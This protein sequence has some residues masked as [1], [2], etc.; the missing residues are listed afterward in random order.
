M[1]PDLCYIVKGWVHER[2]SILFGLYFKSFYAACYNNFLG[3]IFFL[4]MWFNLVIIWS[5][6]PAIRTGQVHMLFERCYWSI[7]FWFLLLWTKVISY[8]HWKR[9]SKTLGFNLIFSMSSVLFFMRASKS[10][11]PSFYNSKMLLMLS[12]FYIVWT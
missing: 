4:C 5:F 12:V 1:K 8:S 6:C 10:C 7:N 11:L 9:C 3:L 2:K